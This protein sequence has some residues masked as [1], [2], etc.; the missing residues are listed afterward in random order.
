MDDSSD[1]EGMFVMLGGD[2]RVFGTGDNIDYSFR[3]W[4][5]FAPLPPPTPSMSTTADPS[6]SSDP[7][8]SLSDKLHIN[9]GAVTVEDLVRD[10][11]LV[12][13][14]LTGAATFWQGADSVD[15]PRCALEEL[16]V[17]GCTQ[18]E[19]SSCPHSSKAPGCTPTLEPI[20][21]RIKCEKQ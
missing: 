13:S 21:L 10:S 1:D 4:R 6:S 11:L 17:G 8:S 19:S 5:N 7:S 14:P 12:D 18:V 9:E 20:S 2:G 3:A 15:A 16:A